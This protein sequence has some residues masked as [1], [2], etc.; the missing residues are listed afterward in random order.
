MTSSS[1]GAGTSSSGSSGAGSS[2]NDGLPTSS[3]SGGSGSGS[4]GSDQCQGPSDTP[5]ICPPELDGCDGANCGGDY[6]DDP[7]IDYGGG[8]TTSSGGSL[9]V[10]H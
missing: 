4:S 2:G 5:E 6:V 10:L 8:G 9:P 1:G 7:T 3:S